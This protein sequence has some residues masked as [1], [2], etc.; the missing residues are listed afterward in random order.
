LQALR[1]DNLSIPAAKGI[2]GFSSE[3]IFGEDAKTSKDKVKAAIVKTA[4]R[5]PEDISNRALR[6]ENLRDFYKNLESKRKIWRHMSVKP[7]AL[8]ILRLERFDHRST[9]IFNWRLL[10]HFREK[11]HIIA[12]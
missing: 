11:I 12:P 8:A 1:I 3:N 6:L 2:F 7:W 4:S 10:V 5:L 9:C